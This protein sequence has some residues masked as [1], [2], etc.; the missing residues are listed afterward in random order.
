ML[1]I[2]ATFNRQWREL[3]THRGRFKDHVGDVIHDDSLP[4]HTE[5]IDFRTFD[6][7]FTT[8]EDVLTELGFEMQLEDID[9][10]EW[11]I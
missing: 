11:Q 4:T 7:G 8:A 3:T 5:V 1:K 6:E 2:N 10:D 9:S